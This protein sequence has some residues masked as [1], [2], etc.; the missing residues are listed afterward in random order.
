MFCIWPDKQVCILATRAVHPVFFT[1][2]VFASLSNARVKVFSIMDRNTEFLFICNSL[3]S[4]MKMT[5]SGGRGLG[6]GVIEQNGKRTRGRGQQC[7]DWEGIRG[8]NGNGKNTI[9]IK[10]KRKRISRFGTGISVTFSRRKFT[11]ILFIF[12]FPWQNCISAARALRLLQVGFQVLGNGEGL[13]WKLISSEF[14]TQGN[15]QWWVTLLV[16]GVSCILGMA[17]TQV[18]QCR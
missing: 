14:D 13:P 8:L 7:G 9:K 2:S 12:I 18:S 1:G 15:Y 3:Y 5:A 11:E 4:T 6:S 16:A 10:L 17:L